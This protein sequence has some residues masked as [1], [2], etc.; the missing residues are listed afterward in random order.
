MKR[1]SST[2]RTIA[3]TTSTT[4]ARCCG[5]SSTGERPS[6]ALASELAD[7]LGG[8]EAQITADLVTITRELGAE[9]LLD[10]VARGER[11][12]RWHRTP[13]VLWRRSLDAVHFLPPGADEPLTLAGT[14]PEL[15]ALLAE[16]RDADDI[17]AAL[18]ELPRRGARPWWHTTCCRCSSSSRRSA[19]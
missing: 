15:W 14:G 2:R 12:S 16:P 8:S 10:G 19:W 17:V 18:A 1:C 6:T 5:R 9:G 7:E 4:P 13:H 11:M 3:S